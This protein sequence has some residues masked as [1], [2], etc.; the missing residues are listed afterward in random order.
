MPFFGGGLDP[1][2]FLVRSLL[3]A[4]HGGRL[5]VRLAWARCGVPPCP[6]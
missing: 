5:P 4:E 1:S 6:G 3:R 2:L